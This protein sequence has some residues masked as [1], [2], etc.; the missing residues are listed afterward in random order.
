MQQTKPSRCRHMISISPKM[1]DILMAIAK[2]EEVSV[3][4]VIVKML[5]E[6]TQPWKLVH[7]VT[8][9][10]ALDPARIQTRYYDLGNGLNA[11]IK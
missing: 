6:Y 11:E 5:E 9:A 3:Q 1:D 10:E 2:H 4:Q 7:P 8:M